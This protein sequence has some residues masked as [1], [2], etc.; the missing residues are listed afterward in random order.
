[1]LIGACLDILGFTIGDDLTILIV[2]FAF[3]GIAFG[4][5]ILRFSRS[6][7]KLKVRVKSPLGEKILLIKPDGFQLPIIKRERKG[8]PPGYKPTFT[9]ASIYRTKGMF[10]LRQI[11]TVDI[12]QGADQCI[13]YDY[14]AKEV[15]APALT[16]AD[17]KDYAEV[18]LL[19]K[20]GEGAKQEHGSMMWIVVIASIVSAAVSILIAHRMGI[21]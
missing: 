11:P 9:L 3:Y 8:G 18:K 2:L 5:L 20:F 15:N 1:M 7:G 19:K 16:K 13:E 6:L 17:V 14:V 10:G 12:I 4:Y 21:F